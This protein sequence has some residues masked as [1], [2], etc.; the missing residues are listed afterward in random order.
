MH[1]C[2]FIR[3]SCMRSKLSLAM[4]AAQARRKGGKGGTVFPG[5]ATFGGSAVAQKY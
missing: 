4:R 2:D 3:Y 1:H 5:P